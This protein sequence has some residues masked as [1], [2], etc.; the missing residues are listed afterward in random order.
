MASLPKADTR[1][2]NSWYDMIRR[3]ERPYV[4]T[5][6]HY[7]GRGIKVCKRWHIF[8]NFWEDMGSDY[9]DNLT[10]ERID[11]NGDY[12]LYNCKWITKR[13]QGYNK[14]NTRYITIGNVTKALAQWIQESNL[15]S[16][17]VRQRYYVLGWDIEKSLNTSVTG[18]GRRVES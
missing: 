9:R 13:E 8:A 7:G 12:E 18:S 6:V 5:Y 10:L 16:S 4:R 11:V 1:P 2:W 14:R 17:T 3:C 15:K